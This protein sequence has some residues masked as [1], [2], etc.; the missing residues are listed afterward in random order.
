MPHAALIRK[1][2][3]T[4]DYFI[5]VVENIQQRKSA[6]AD[7]YRINAHLE[8]RVIERTAELTAANQELDSFAYAISHDLRA[9]LRAM[10]GFS[11]ALEEDFGRQLQGEAKLFLNQIEIAGH[12]MNELVDGLLALSRSTRGEIEHVMVDLSTMAKRQLAELAQDESERKVTIKVE[13]DPQTHGDTGMIE[14]VMRN[15]LSNAWKYSGQT[16]AASIRVYAE[17]WQGQQYLLCRR[18][19]RRFRHG[20][21]QPPVP[22]LPASAPAGRIPG[23]GLATVKCNMHRHGGIIEARGKP[24]KGTTFCFSLAA[25]LTGVT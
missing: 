10:V 1:T 5:S 24:G 20:P 18:P 25:A 4:P 21:R 6:E 14:V 22:A 9:P 8:Q 16:A 19:R 17:E 15:L 12:K 23:I 13:T 3:V 7:I 11:Q 2:D